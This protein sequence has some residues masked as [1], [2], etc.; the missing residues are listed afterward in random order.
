M[1][2]GIWRDACGRDEH[3]R[4]TIPATQSGSKAAVTF[5][6][7]H[8]EAMGFEGFVR[9]SDLLVAP[10]QAPDACGI[11]VVVR[12]S[13]G[14]PSF[15]EESPGGR[16]KDHDPSYP[17]RRLREKWVSG[18]KIIYV[19]K[20]G[21]TRRRTLRRRINEFLRFG[22]GE[23]IA[24]RGG[25]AIWHLQDVLTYKIAWRVCDRGDPRI[26]EKRLLR[27]FEKAYSKLPF[28]NFRR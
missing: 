1:C 27:E 19:G 10:R 15:L 6:R 18:A 11:Y 3:P 17:M 14:T 22:S 21:P 2:W 20:A 4:A 5:D 28:G 7:K 8:L 9:L 16:F 25:R 26:H 24:H 13:G 23:P 12:R